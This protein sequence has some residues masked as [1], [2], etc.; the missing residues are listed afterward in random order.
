MKEESEGSLNKSFLS[1]HSKDELKSINK[2]FSPLR[3]DGPN[4]LNKSFSSVNESKVN[5]SFMERSRGTI[6]RQEDPGHMGSKY[7]RSTSKSVVLLDSAK[8]RRKPLSSSEEAISPVA[9]SLWK[10]IK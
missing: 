6:L 9:M 2:S 1:T 7:V 3:K 4:F 8:K 5:S 10:S